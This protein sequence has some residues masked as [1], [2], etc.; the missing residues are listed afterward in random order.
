MEEMI[1]IPKKLLDDLLVKLDILEKRC[2]FLENEN[3]NLKLEIIKLK[4]NSTTSSKP[5]STD[6]IST[7]KKSKYPNKESSNKK[8]GGQFGHTKH[9]RTSFEEV[10]VYEDFSLSFCPA[11][12]GKLNTSEDKENRIVQQ[13]EIVESPIIISEYESKVYWCENCSCHHYAQLPS[14]V[15]KGGLLGPRITGLVGWLKGASHNPYTTIQQFL[16]SVLGVKVSRGLLAK[17]VQKCSNSI[18]EAYD[19]LL[20]QVKLAQHVNIDE[21]GHKENG[22]RMWTWCFRTEL[23]CLFLIDKSRGS[24]VLL[25]VLGSEFNGMIG[26]DFFSAYRKFMKDLS[27]EVQFCIAHLIR[28]LKFLTTLDDK[29]TADYGERLLLE[30]KELFYIMSDA[31]RSDEE[32]KDELTSQS[33][34]IL[35]IS[36]DIVPFNKYAQNI[37]NRFIKYGENYFKFITT[38]EIDATNNIA[39]QAIIFVVIDRL[40]TQG[41]RSEKGREWC[42]RIWSILATCDIQKTSSFQF[43]VDS[44]NAHFEGT[45]P[46]KL[47]QT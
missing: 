47:L 16:Q 26:C 8:I 9:T 42:Q 13:V 11:C 35:N 12:G 5:P 1:T 24:Q 20:K 34:T 25:K 23:Y 19:D 6:S 29:P 27:L 37:K 44:V 21:T 36:S 33:F 14:S 15:E 31:S 28:E 40:I 46:P 4:K 10:D 30:V 17:T 18:S 38:P 45:D 39:E 32:K 43:L 3:T 2:A 41:T 7:N 22:E